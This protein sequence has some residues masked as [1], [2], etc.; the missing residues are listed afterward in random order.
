MQD[1]IILIPIQQPLIIPQREPKALVQFHTN[2]TASKNIIA[3]ITGCAFETVDIG[4]FCLDP[5]TGADRWGDAAEE[6]HLKVLTERNVE[7][8]ADGNVHIDFVQAGRLGIELFIPVGA[9]IDTGAVAED[10]REALGILE[11]QLDAI[12]VI[13]STTFLEIEPGGRAGAD[14]DL[15]RSVR[16]HEYQCRGKEKKKRLF[17]G[18][19][20]MWLVKDR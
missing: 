15:C 19:Q 3:E 1:P 18:Y 7:L 13:D 2:T 8:H 9:E 6:E 20:S 16:A 4:R 17:H 11:V 14:A 12:G 10:V 5:G